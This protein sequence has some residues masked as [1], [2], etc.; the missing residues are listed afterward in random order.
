MINKIPRNVLRKKKHKRLR[1]RIFGTAVKP[2]LSVFRSNNHI[3]AQI[4]DDTVGH[5]LCAASTL[6]EDGKKLDRTDDVAAA[7]FVGEEIARKAIEKGIKEVIFD[8][9]GYVYHGKV[10]A[11]AMAARDGG[12][13]F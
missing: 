8:R 10:E 6:G 9:S 2:R 1:N 4:I 13:K 5:T 11:L 12:L 3:Y 7:T